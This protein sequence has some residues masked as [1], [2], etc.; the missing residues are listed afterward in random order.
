[1]KLDAL[2]SLILSGDWIVENALFP[3][4]I[5]ASKNP[6]INEKNDNL[7]ILKNGFQDL[8]FPTPSPSPYGSQQDSQNQSQ[9]QTQS[10]PQIIPIK[11]FEN[12]LF[13][14]NVRLFNMISA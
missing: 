10:L 6:K 13:N 5:A 4:K 2:Q 11:S 8:S 3:E 14:I 1:M 12:E 7:P 9:I